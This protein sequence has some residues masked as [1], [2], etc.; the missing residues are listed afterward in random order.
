MLSEEKMHRINEL[1]RKAKTEEGLT[2]SEQSEQKELREE[3]LHRF[4]KGMR[5]HIEGM[6]VVDEEG[7]DVTP[8]KLKDIQ[9]KKGLH[10][11]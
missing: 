5:H 6:K 11:R 10:G 1:A 3:Y 7:T 4:R 2:L 8:D 9:K